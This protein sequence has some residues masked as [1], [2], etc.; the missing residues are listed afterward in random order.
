MRDETRRDRLDLVSSRDFISR[1]R[2][3]S[4][5]V[6][7]LSS[8]YRPYHILTVRF[9][10]HFSP[11]RNF[12]SAG[13][14]LFSLQSLQFAPKQPTTTKLDRHFCI[15]HII[16]LFKIKLPSPHYI[17]FTSCRW[18]Y[19][20]S[21]SW[22]IHLCLDKKMNVFEKVKNIQRIFFHLENYVLLRQRS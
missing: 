20:S 16:F 8:R 10:L 14:Q 11:F 18:N 17:S 22:K 6:S 7:W 3:V 2:L 15:M 19:L 1:D 12:A 4:R 9:S 5:L 13:K 21:F